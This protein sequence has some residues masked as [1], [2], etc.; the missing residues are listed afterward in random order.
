MKPPIKVAKPD[1][2]A[3]DAA[4]AALVELLSMRDEIG[5]VKLRAYAELRKWSRSLV[6]IM[7]LSDD[8]AEA[9][10]L[11]EAMVKVRHE[12][13]RLSV[14]RDA[15]N[16][17]IAN[18]KATEEAQRARVAELDGRIAKLTDRVAELDRERR[19]L[20]PTV[21]SHRALALA[22]EASQRQLSELRAEEARI[23]P[24][25]VESR[26]VELALP[27]KLEQLRSVEARLASIRASI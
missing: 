5:S 13:N 27:E 18:L 22:I 21:E 7:L 15:L 12:H 25:L 8:L 11:D 24:L 14:E 26:R 10:S 17:S 23:R 1:D 9:A 3:D 16:A 20:E 19:Q 2:P 4:P 6:G